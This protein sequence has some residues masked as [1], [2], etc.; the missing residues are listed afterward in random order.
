MLIRRF[1]G[2]AHPHAHKE[3]TAPLATV[4]LPLPAKLIIPV[5][6]HIG[7][8]AIPTV[9]VGDLVKKGQVIAD[10]ENGRTPPIHATTS[11]KVVDIGTQPHPLFGQ[12]QS[13][14]LEPDGQDEWQEGLLTDRK[15]EELSAEELI[16][17]VFRAGI[18]GMGGAAF[19]THMKLAPP[20]DKMIDTLIINGAECEPYLTSDYR[21]MLE[22]PDLVITGCR[23]VMEILNVHTAVIGIEDNKPDAVQ[24]LVERCQGTGITV[25]AV[26]T[27]YPQGAE[28]ML[29][30]ALTGRE[31][32]S[33]K[34]PMDVG[35]VV[36]NVG[37]LTAVAQAVT[38]NIPLI[39]RVVTVSGSPVAEPK[40]L[41]TRIGTPFS[42]A[43]AYCG[44]TTR[45]PGKV[46]MGGPMMGLAQI[47]LT[48]PV[49]KSTSGITVFDKKDSTMPK[50]RSCVR[51]GRC[52]DAC[53]MRLRP[54]MLSILSE[55]GRHQT[56]HAEFDLMD[57][58]ECGCCSYVCPSKRN[59][60]H[61]I[62][63]S[64]A[65]NA[66]ARAVRK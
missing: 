15:W 60:V 48:A 10:H 39:E 19:P 12:A 14:V 51:C 28:K 34:L 33:G 20:K 46:L 54:N 49:I 52:L 23:I 25:A 56:A 13:I 45:E 42:H 16:K 61:Y 4:S 66:L 29:I 3:R 27:R 35:C 47:N 24:A 37:T 21:T 38:R 7:D 50:E 22:Q 59:I 6:Q 8:P 63:Q 53:T 44:G 40:N 26:Q 2:G 65:K 5:R 9:K 36:Q 64:K 57:C 58:V 17:I 31:V 18:V 43:L 62:K 55:M 41:L 32:P 1:R 30:W 11:G